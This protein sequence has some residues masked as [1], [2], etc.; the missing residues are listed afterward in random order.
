MVTKNLSC[1]S[2][3]HTA[4]GWKPRL[5]QITY[6]RISGLSSY[7]IHPQAEFLQGRSWRPR[8]RAFRRKHLEIFSLGRNLLPEVATGESRKS[9]I[10]KERPIGSV[11][12]IRTGRR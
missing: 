1:R 2:P 7:T 4:V 10:S 5:R 6:I 12:A 9:F 11:D 8:Q 3:S